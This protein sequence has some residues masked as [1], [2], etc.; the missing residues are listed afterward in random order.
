MIEDFQD[1]AL[2]EMKRICR[3]KLI[4][5]TPNE[6]KTNEQAIDNAWDLG[7]NEYQIHRCLLDN[8]KLLNLG[9]KIR[10]DNE[11]AGNF[12]VWLKR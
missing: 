1:K 8:T 5:Y 7:Y 11:D 9:F 4:I 3:K 6:F 10:N 2:E 12:G